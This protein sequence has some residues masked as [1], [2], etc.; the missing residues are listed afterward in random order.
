M[1][2]KLKQ[3][4]IKH[5]T[6]RKLQRYLKPRNGPARGTYTDFVSTA[7]ELHLEAAK[8]ANSESSQKKEAA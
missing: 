2:Q 3:V 7:A 1:P 4:W 8:T 5:S 6:H